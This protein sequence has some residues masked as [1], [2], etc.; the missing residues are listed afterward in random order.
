[1]R[2]VVETEG[3]KGQN[4]LKGEFGEDEG[5]VEAVEELWGGS[6]LVFGPLIRFLL[7]E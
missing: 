1:M 2:N 3:G 6:V 5:C 4:R 7:L